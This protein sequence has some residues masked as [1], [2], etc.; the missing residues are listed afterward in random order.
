[1]P[2]PVIV[3]SPDLLLRQKLVT[4]IE[5]IG[6]VAVGAA[7]ETRL[8]SRLAN[9]AG[10]L[11]IEMDADGVDAVTLLS[12]L[13]TDPATAG[14]PIAGFCAHTREDLIQD[15]RAAGATMVVSRGA[16]VRK[17]PA[18]VEELLDGPAGDDPP[19]AA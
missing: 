9:G 10:A 17:L 6:R 16:I 12:E 7:S 13:R 2:A 11:I 15:A 5:A 1:M 3:Y 19:A 14:L 18:V 4:G 8:R